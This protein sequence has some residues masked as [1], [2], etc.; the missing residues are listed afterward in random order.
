MSDSWVSPL[1]VDLETMGAMAARV[2]ELVTTHLASLRDQPVRITLSRPEAKRP[3][4]TVAAIAPE[5]D[6]PS[7]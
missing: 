4:G 2:S 1:E 5:R 7:R 3:V 6:R